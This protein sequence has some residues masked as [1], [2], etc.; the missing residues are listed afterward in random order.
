MNR[1]DL[2]DVLIK[3]TDLNSSDAKKVVNIFFDS[4][5]NALA[6]DQRVEVRGFGS[7]TVKRYK[8]YTGRNPKTGQKTDV[9]DKKLPFFKAGKELKDKVD[10]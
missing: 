8:G 1:S 6:Q 4:I 9:Q 7:F 10:C 3:E 5:K 2:I